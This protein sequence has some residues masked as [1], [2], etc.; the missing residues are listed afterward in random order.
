MSVLH[1]KI[2]HQLLEKNSLISP[3]SEV[4]I[5]SFPT[6]KMLFLA[7]Q[8]LNAKLPTD[9]YEITSAQQHT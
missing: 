9:A 1:Y 4:D 3:R 5:S 8:A 6:G 7:T 2:K